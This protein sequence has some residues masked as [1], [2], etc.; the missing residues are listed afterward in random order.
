MRIDTQGL[1]A[2][3]LMTRCK[4]CRSELP[5][6]DGCKSDASPRLEEP[7]R[8]RLTLIKHRTGCPVWEGACSRRGRYIRHISRR[9]VA[10]REQAPSH[11]CY[12]L[13]HGAAS[14]DAGGP[15]SN[16]PLPLAGP[17]C[18]QINH[19]ASNQAESAN[20]PPVDSDACRGR[21][22]IGGSGRRKPVLAPR[23][24]RARRVSPGPVR[25]CSR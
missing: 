7:S 18:I 19:R 8:A 13:R 14:D 5:Q 3:A 12:L 9:Q 1:A 24:G 11:D 2:L 21:R 10:D 15:R 4:P 23:P 17:S 16:T 20:Y 25:C 6:D 22:G